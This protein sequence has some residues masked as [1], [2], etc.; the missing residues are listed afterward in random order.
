MA[1]QQIT[2]RAPARPAIGLSADNEIPDRFTTIAIVRG[3]ASSLSL[4][5]PVI[6]TLDALLSCLPPQ[7]RHHSVFASNAT[8]CA[9]L[10]G[11]SDRTLRR[12]LAIL[13]EL[14][15]LVRRDSPNRKRF[16]RS[17]PETGSRL[18]FGFDL[19]PLFDRLP[20]LAELAAAVERQTERLRFLRLRLRA[21]LA[22]A[23][24]RHPDDPTL[25]STQRLLR[26]RVSVEE[27]EFELSR[28][29]PLEALRCAVSTNEMSV[30]DGHFDR[31][32]Y[33][34]KKEPMNKE[35]IVTRNDSDPSDAEHLLL[36]EC[37]EAIDFAS[38]PITCVK[39]VVELSRSLAPMIGV[40]EADYARA[41]YERGEMF[42]TATICIIVALAA[43]LRSPTHYF[44]ALIF[45]RHAAHFNPWVYLRSMRSRRRPACRRNAERQIELSADNLAPTVAN[46]PTTPT[47]LRI[48]KEFRSAVLPAHLECHDRSGTPIPLPKGRGSQEA[49]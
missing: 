19:Q 2:A 46:R 1:F 18:C 5:P 12:H 44:R 25:L 3:A 26:R 17:D 42:T 30:N 40:N 28:L 38:H 39:D 27:L 20:G 31:H 32:H 10:S 22:R 4:K 49:R 43:N 41:L 21:A 23:L 33:I 29:P 48:E 37:S 47:C 13:Q 45:G 11:I 14:G 6:A 24:E 36:S 8:L 16:T 35:P 7:R 15:L 34:L 9:R